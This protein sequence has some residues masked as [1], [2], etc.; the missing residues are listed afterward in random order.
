M[1]VGFRAIQI[2]YK[3]ICNLFAKLKVFSDLTCLQAVRKYDVLP[4]S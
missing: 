1:W 4:D 3:R 2:I